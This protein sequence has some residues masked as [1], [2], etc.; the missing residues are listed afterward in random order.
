MWIDDTMII[1]DWY[2]SG[3]HQKCADIAL[4]SGWHHVRLDYFNGFVNAA[5]KLTWSSAS[6]TGGANEVVPT[7]HLDPN[8]GILLDIGLNASYYDDVSPV[9]TPVLTQEILN[10]DYDWYIGSPD[11]LV[12]NDAF[13]ARYEGQVRIVEN[14]NYNFITYSDDGV[15]VWVDG[16]LVIDDWESQSRTKNESGVVSLSV[17][18]YDLVVEYY[19]Y[20]EAATISL[21]WTTPSNPTEEVIPASFLT[22]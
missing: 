8:N 22:H 19:D 15:R 13:S 21:L 12:P 20:A 16:N 6:Q 18:T 7:D 4:T 5:A 2:P 14:G 11:P 1:Q 9:G 17:G 10:V 3:L